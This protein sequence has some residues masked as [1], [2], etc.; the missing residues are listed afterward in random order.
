[1]SLPPVPPLPQISHLVVVPPP[2]PL[3]L[4]PER[5]RFDRLMRKLYQLTLL[6]AEWVDQRVAV[7]KVAAW[8][9]QPVKRA[10]HQH[11]KQLAWR[12]DA[13]FGAPELDEM[14]RI[15]LSW[16]ICS[17]AEQVL[18]LEDDPAMADLLD[19]HDVARWADAEDIPWDEEDVFTA[20]GIV[21]IPPPPKST[22]T[23]SA[24]GTAPQAPDH[25][26]VIGLLKEVW[27]D[28]A[29]LDALEDPALAG[30]CEL[31]RREIHAVG[32]ALFNM[33]IPLSEDWQLPL[34]DI[35]P[36][37]AIHMLRQDVLEVQAEIA[38]AQRQVQELADIGALKARLAAYELPDDPGEGEGA[39]FVAMERA[40]DWNRLYRECLG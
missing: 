19:R 2:P 13:V 11:L 28:R 5:R 27:H 40:P 29:C 17:F 15:K 20:S 33:L 32:A 25:M 16:L 30:Y 3:P 4:S 8:E 12:F 7:R 36:A 38:I 1:M 35:T 9:L 26:Q 24:G 37:G 23:D 18:A 10:L 6:A 14:D 34:D 21:H 22:A 39:W 31:A